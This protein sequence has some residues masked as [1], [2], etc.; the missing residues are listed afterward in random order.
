MVHEKPEER[1][2]ERA[3]GVKLTGH[4]SESLTTEMKSRLEAKLPRRW[5]HHWVKISFISSW[6]SDCL[7][8]VC[9]GQYLSSWANMERWQSPKSKPQIF[10]FLSAEPVAIIVLSWLRDTQGQSREDSGLKWVLQLIILISQQ[11]SHVRCPDKVQAAYVHT[12]T[13]RTG[14]AKGRMCRYDVNSDMKPVCGKYKFKSNL[15]CRTYLKCVCV[16]DLDCAV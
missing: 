8:W 16:E 14:A 5:L 1:A 10:T 11:Y 6:T 13:R 4:R 9:A 2:D 12:E 3:A 15:V 7:V